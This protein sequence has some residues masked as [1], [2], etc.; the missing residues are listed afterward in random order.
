[1]SGY[2]E[3]H[4]FRGLAVVGCVWSISIICSRFRVLAAVQ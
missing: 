3:Q 4:G 1:M 2:Q